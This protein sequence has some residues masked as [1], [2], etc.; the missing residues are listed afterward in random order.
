MKDPYVTSYSARASESPREHLTRMEASRAPHTFLGRAA[1]VNRF[2]A[3]ALG[4]L[5]LMA[6]ACAS[7]AATPDQPVTPAPREENTPVP[8]AAASPSLVIVEQPT[9]EP[10]EQAAPEP[11]VADAAPEMD[12]VDVP[13]PIPEVVRDL[14]PRGPKQLVADAFYQLLDRDDIFPIYEPII[15][16]AQDAPMESN[17]LVIGVSIAGESRAYPIRALRF[18]EMVNDELGGVPILVTW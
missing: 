5:A 12:S 15:A 4:V 17:D 14:N 6:V 3:L 11:A 18:R 9:P 7:P 1:R 13:D 2:V 10:V 16:A 8:P